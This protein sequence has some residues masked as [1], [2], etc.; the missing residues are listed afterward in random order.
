MYTG[1]IL[2]FELKETFNGFTVTCCLS[3][4]GLHWIGYY[5]SIRITV[6]W[7]IRP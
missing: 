5:I 2:Y 4:L 7:F 1:L 3:F 6:L